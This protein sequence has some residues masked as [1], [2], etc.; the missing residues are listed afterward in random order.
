MK[1]SSVHSLFPDATT[2]RCQ[3]H[4]SQ[5][6]SLCNGSFFLRIWSCSVPSVRKQMVD[7]P[8]ECKSHMSFASSPR[9]LLNDRKRVTCVLK[10]SAVDISTSHTSGNKK[11]STST[12]Q[13]AVASLDLHDLI[14]KSVSSGHCDEGSSRICAGRLFRRRRCHH[15]VA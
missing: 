6:R 2:F 15:F 3:K 13:R 1:S 7:G 14:T 5:K 12:G 10:K 11:R 8:C 4:A 9:A